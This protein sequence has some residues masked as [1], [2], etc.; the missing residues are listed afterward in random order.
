MKTIQIGS[1]VTWKSAGKVARAA[2]VAG[3]IV[4][5]KVVELARDI[6]GEDYITVK[7]TYQ[8]VIK[9]PGAASTVRDINSLVPLSKILSVK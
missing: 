4:S 7:P 1:T 9:I 5:G 2:G 3:K 6:D 8:Y